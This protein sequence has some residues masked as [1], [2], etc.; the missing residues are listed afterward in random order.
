MF[1][2]IKLGKRKLGIQNS[3]KS[4]QKKK[5]TLTK[6]KYFVAKNTQF[7]ACAPPPKSSNL[8]VPQTHQIYRQTPLE[9][10][11][12]KTKNHSLVWWYEWESKVLLVQ[13][14]SKEISWRQFLSLA[15]KISSS[16]KGHQINIYF[17][18]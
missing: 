11:W 4:K 13:D 18:L 15:N 9:M 14:N 1:Y 7:G 2:F 12:V 8:I 17:A 6:P 10:C 3:K 5:V 16:S